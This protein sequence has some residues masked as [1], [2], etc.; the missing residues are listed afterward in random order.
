MNIAP[1]TQEILIALDQDP[2][3]HI[4]AATYSWAFGNRANVAAAF[5]IARK[6]DMIR[7]RHI[8]T[9]GNPVYVNRNSEVYY[10]LTAV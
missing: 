6:S 10:T 1:K 8:S 4:T 5:R 7:V 3:E 9:A 2:S